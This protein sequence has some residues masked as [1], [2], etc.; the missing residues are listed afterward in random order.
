[1]A[2]V[3]IRRLNRCQHL[4]ARGVEV[5]LLGLAFGAVVQDGADLVLGQLCHGRLA[6]FDRFASAEVGIH[7]R[8]HGPAEGHPQGQRK[9]RQR[10]SRVHQPGLANQGKQPHGPP[11]IR[12]GKVLKSLGGV[13]EP[14]Q[15]G[16]AHSRTLW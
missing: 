5:G 3:A 8:P 10:A 13:V 1:M 7:G 15:V 2:G 16:L 12:V 11:Q 6:T 14:R 4:T 9:V